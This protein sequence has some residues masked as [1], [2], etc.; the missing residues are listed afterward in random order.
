MLIRWQKTIVDQRG[1]VQPG[2]VLNIRRESDQALVAVYRD[3]GGADP[4]PTGSVTAD[5]NGYAYFYAP[6][7]TYRITS[8]K[9]AIDWRDEGLTTATITFNGKTY[10]DVAAMEADT[11]QPVGTVGRVSTG[12]GAG[13]YAMTASGWEWSDVQPASSE[14]VQQLQ[15]QDALTIN[16]G[17]V[18]PLS[19]I[20]RDGVISPAA[21]GIGIPYW[22]DAILAVRVSGSPSQINGKYFRIS[23]IDNGFGGRNG[24][25]LT[26]YPKDTYATAS[27]ETIIHERTDANYNYGAS[28]GIA[29]VV[30]EP[31][32][33]PGMRFEITIDGS[34]LPPFGTPMNAG[35]SG[36]PAWSWII[37][38]SCVHAEISQAYDGLT[39]NAGKN[40]PLRPASRAG[41]M[42]PLNAAFNAALLNVRVI[43]ADLSKVYR[44]AY[45]VNESTALPGS[46]PFGWVFESFDAQTYGVSD[47]SRIRLHN[48]TDPAPAIDRLGGIQTIRISTAV[49]P[50]VIFE[51]T[52]DA[53]RLPPSGTPI[54][55][56]TA[57]QVDGY[58]WIVDPT[59]YEAA[60][61]V[62]GLAQIRTLY[63]S[64]TE[65]SISHAWGAPGR[66]FRVRCGPNGYN[67]LFNI[68]GVDISTDDSLADAVWTDTGT[69]TTDCFPPFQVRKVTG[70]TPVE[71]RIFTG[72]NHGKDGSTGGGNTGRMTFCQVFVDG[73][74]V[75]GASL[76]GFANRARVVWSNEVMAYNT[77]AD[78]E[79]VLRQSMRADFLPEQIVLAST[80]TN[81][82]DADIAI[83]TDYGPQS[84]LSALWR[85][86]V[87][88]LGGQFATRMPWGDAENSGNKSLYP[89]AWLYAAK[90]SAGFWGA[91][92]DKS[93][94][95]GDG[96][97]VIGETPLIRHTSSKIYHA[98]VF[99]GS[100]GGLVLQPGESYTWRGGYIWLP[101]E[102]QGTGVD[103][104]YP[105]GDPVRTAL[106][107]SA[108]SWDVV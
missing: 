98:A 15:A 31:T 108:Q 9:P 49:D 56:L 91:W 52:L 86:T 44:I 22:N 4:Y 88:M 23:N 65:D 103:A 90:G 72:G 84:V 32:L 45:F 55:A 26:E 53:S 66:L 10:V 20:A 73:G 105:F 36:S 59:L 54:R 38:P 17:K 48:Y 106:A 78:D 2:A 5:E 67:N 51:I 57:G 33:R 80:V 30:I 89:Q 35:T 25:R 75:S 107:Y 41:V 13:D 43:G 104:A 19:A 100:S 85:D 81:I 94:G 82:T 8:L 47:S 11:S 87:L 58:S 3:R 93:F 40:F 83:E 70:S 97:F 99:Q 50:S 64:A 69:F 62:P 16:R 6:A 39:V 12:A 7:G 76:S 71:P 77:I 1:N 61:S 14:D 28:L 63:V 79:Y 60:A 68:Q 27:V 21:A 29:T 46:D 102:A 18:F 74:L 96:E 37:D 42:S 24:I 101:P 92:L 95:V 34:Q